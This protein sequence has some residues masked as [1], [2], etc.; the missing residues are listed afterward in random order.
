MCMYSAHD[1]YANDFHLVH[2]GQLAMRGVGAVVIEA[3]GVLPEG[4]LTPKCLGLWHD[5]HITGLKRVVDYMHNFGAMVGVQLSHPG[6]KGS[7]IPFH[8]YGK[9]PNKAFVNAAARASQAGF[10]FI[11]IHGAHGYL[12]NQ[13]LSPLSNTRT[14]M[15]GGS[16]ENRIRFVSEIVQGVRKVWPAEK[17]LFVRLSVREWVEGGW[18]VD[19]SIA[20]TKK[21]HELGVDLV[22]CSSAGNDTREK[23]PAS[24][25][26]LVPL[27]SAIKECVPG[28]LT[29]A[30]GIITGG[31]Q[32]NNILEQGMADVIFAGRQFLHDPSFVMNSAL[33]LG[34][35][36]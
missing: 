9:R 26:Y 5:G 25:G 33:E 30:V 35:F 18:T 19:D 36:I 16:F 20:L 32:A 12:I 22:G 1:G 17:P 15:Y 2:Y 29:G 7:T 23:V 8:M 3:T 13:F 21:M 34:V 11:E 4:R 24:P 31:K 6:R 14:D 10:D 28:I 27:S